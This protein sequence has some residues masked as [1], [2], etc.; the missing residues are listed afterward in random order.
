ME[1]LKQKLV[2]DNRETMASS[3]E[4]EKRM[5]LQIGSKCMVYS[6]LKGQWLSAK[7]MNV[8]TDSEG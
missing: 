7:V 5:S 3:L 2:T 6:D 8:Y 4:R 1:T